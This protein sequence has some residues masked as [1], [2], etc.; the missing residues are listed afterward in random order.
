MK[1][2]QRTGA[3]RHV[4]LKTSSFSSVVSETDASA[5]CCIEEKMYPELGKACG[6]C[7]SALN[8]ALALAYASHLSNT[9]RLVV[10]LP[11]LFN[12]HRVQSEPADTLYLTC[13]EEKAPFALSSFPPHLF[14]LA[15][16][17]DLG[18]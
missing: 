12:K 4:L 13:V 5:L 14:T 7:I 16:P 15:F 9:I 17:K 8:S 11:A 6:D 3:I 18:V 10:T 2:E 1:P